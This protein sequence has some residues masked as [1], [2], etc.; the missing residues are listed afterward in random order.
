MQK[1]ELQ[2]QKQAEDG[3]KFIEVMI[4][5]FSSPAEKLETRRFSKTEKLPKKKI[6]QYISPGGQ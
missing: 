3:R 2:V 5:Y 6:E 1:L 4:K